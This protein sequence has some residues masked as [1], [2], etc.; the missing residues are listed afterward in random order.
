MPSHGFTGCSRFSWSDVSMPNHW[1]G[2][3]KGV[4]VPVQVAE[5]RPARTGE[6]KAPPSCGSLHTVQVACILVIFLEPGGGFAV[7]LAAQE[8]QEQQ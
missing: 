7:A 2:K 4:R 5:R 6:K 1:G 8:Q 3:N